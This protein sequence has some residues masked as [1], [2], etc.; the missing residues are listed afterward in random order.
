MKSEPKRV[1]TLLLFLLLL[2]AVGCVPEESMLAEPT[3]ELQDHLAEPTSETLSTSNPEPHQTPAAQAMELSGAPVEADRDSSTTVSS[4]TVISPTDDPCSGAGVAGFQG[5]SPGVPVTTTVSTD[6]S[7]CVGTGV[8]DDQETSVTSSDQDD[9]TFSIKE[10]VVGRVTAPD[11][12][13]VKGALI[14]PRSLD[15]P[16]PPIPE[17]AIHTDKDGRYMWP[18]FPGTYELSVRPKGYQRP[19]N[20]ITVTVTAGQVVIADWTLEPAP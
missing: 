8:V 6:G 1:V 13:P 5:G 12:S 20:P 2:L 3:G 4:T 14:E 16:S 9:Q 15:D 19:I 7:P 10:G 17:I 18:L 11:G